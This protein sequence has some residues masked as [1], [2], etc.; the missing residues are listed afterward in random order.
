MTDRH[1]GL[2]INRLRQ[3]GLLANTLVIFFTDHG[4]SHARGKQFLYD[5]GTHIPVVVSGPGIVGGTTRTDL[6][7]HIDIAALSLAAAGI[8]IPRAM[9]GRNILVLCQCLILG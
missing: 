9:Q 3:E 6:I 7:E 8:E 5:E 4:I 1:V 2:V